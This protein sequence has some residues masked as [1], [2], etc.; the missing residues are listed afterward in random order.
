MKKLILV[1]II[2]I[3]TSFSQTLLLEENF[4]Y[5]IGTLT[6]ST[7]NWIENPN[8]SVDIQVVSG[9]LSH[10]NYLSSGIGNKIVVNGGAQGRS[11]V[12]RQFEEQSGNGA[13]VYA[14]FLL[15]VTSTEDMDADTSDGDRFFNLKVSNS[16]AFRCCVFVRKGSSSSKFQIGFGKLNTSTPSWYPAELDINSTYLIVVA[17]VFQ[18]GADVARFWLNPDLNGE[19]PSPDLEQS[20]GGDADDLGEVQFRQ[21]I[22]SGDE[23][24]DGLR[25]ATDW[26]LAPLPVELSSFS[27]IRI[28]EGVRLKWRTETEVR[29]YGFEILRSAENHNWEVLSFVEGH[30]NSNSPK[31]Y[32]FIDRSADFG[33]Y[34]YRLKQI[35]T[36]GK[37]EYSKIVEVNLGLPEKFEL[38]Q[39]YPNP[40]NPVT[41]IKFVLSEPGYVKLTIYNLLGEKV[42]SLVDEFLD[43]GTHTINFN[44]ESLNSG[45]YL[46]RL[47]TEHFADFKKMLLVK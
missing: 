25:I 26:S 4:E 11:G 34:S 9:S 20:T 1:L 38:S 12:L 3:S 21:G 5:E 46:Y 23:E 10:S 27:A 8:G 14:S 15:N 31:D 32:S 42:T 6:S 36:D 37:F 41:T 33:N 47:E 28:D 29:N 39:N 24:I 43:V 40:F 18:T 16:S 22:L 2:I 19:E 7:N 44:G 17:Y 45:F 35:D 13:K 30:G